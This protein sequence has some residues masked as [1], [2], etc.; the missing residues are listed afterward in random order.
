M[1]VA[2]VLCSSEVETISGT[3]IGGRFRAR[4]APEKATFDPFPT[5][6][7]VS[8]PVCFFSS[9]LLE[10]D[11]HQ[12]GCSEAVAETGSCHCQRHGGDIFKRPSFNGLTA[13]VSAPRIEQTLQAR[14]FTLPGAVEMV[15]GSAAHSRGLGALPKSRWGFGINKISGGQPLGA[16]SSIRAGRTPRWLYVCS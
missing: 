15:V 7:G 16:F 1:F 11:A 12:G 3:K 14:R 6:L 13:S 9:S 8:F 2:D 10:D 5:V 4:I